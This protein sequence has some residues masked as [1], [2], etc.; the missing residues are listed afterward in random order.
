MQEGRWETAGKPD[1][2]WKT[3]PAGRSGEGSV[4]A[5]AELESRNANLEI[6]K[7]ASIFL[8]AGDLLSSI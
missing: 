5:I 3:A 6:C 7:Q 8:A 4:K 1:G 2:R